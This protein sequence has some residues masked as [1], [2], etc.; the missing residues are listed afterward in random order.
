MTKKEASNVLCT[1]NQVHN[2]PS[3]E[4]SKKD[5]RKV[6]FKNR[7]GSSMLMFKD[8]TPY[9]AAQRR[10]ALKRIYTDWRGDFIIT[11]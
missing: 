5:V 4:T 7:S 8:L 3:K 10:K 9:D 11:R 6:Y 2:I 1:K